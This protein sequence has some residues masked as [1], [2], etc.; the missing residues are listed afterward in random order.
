MGEESTGGR[1]G[2]PHGDGAAED[3]C[4]REPCLPEPWMC[5]VFRI[6]G[7]LRDIRILDVT[8]DEWIAVLERL[9]V[10]ADEVEIDH[11]YPRLDPTHPETT[12]LFRAW[13][14]E[15][16]GR[17]TTFAFRARFGDVWFFAL[18]LH[19]EEI[20]FSVWPDRVVDGAGVAAVRRFLTEIATA[21]RRPSVLTA[22]CATYA[23]GM[24]TL[25]S[26]DPA[27]GLD[28]HV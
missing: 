18:P 17:G 8:G 12:E 20:E 22:E 19:E 14:H 6:D 15:P 3:R 26:H 9:R 28:F 4:G 25:M 7:S 24:P 13:A 2:V 10:V 27:T 1:V 11:P 23:S 16:E 21:G 5:D